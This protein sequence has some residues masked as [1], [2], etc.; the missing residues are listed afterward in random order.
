[1]LELLS[2]S[3]LVLVRDLLVVD[4]GHVGEPVHDERAHQSG[5]GHLVLVDVDLVEGLDRLQLGDLYERVYVVVH[6]VEA[7]QL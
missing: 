7:F 1:M 3:L 5:L 2:R 6:E 4:H